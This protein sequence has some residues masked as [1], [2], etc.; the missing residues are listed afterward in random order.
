M[1]GFNERPLNG[2]SYL[3]PESVIESGNLPLETWAGCAE[4]VIITLKD[5][6]A[7]VRSS[8]EY[9][10]LPLGP[11][12]Y[13]SG[14]SSDGVHPESGPNSWTLVDLVHTLIDADPETRFTREEDGQ[15]IDDI[16]GKF[17]NRRVEVRNVFDII[18]SSD[19]PVLKLKLKGWGVKWLLPEEAGKVANLQAAQVTLRQKQDFRNEFR[20]RGIQALEEEITVYLSGQA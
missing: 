1:A 8:G 14:D 9:T 3:S 13:P 20:N 17:H 12:S 5:V 16:R 19:S 18:S 6:T 4:R 15:L 7:G 10:P 11:D 2:D